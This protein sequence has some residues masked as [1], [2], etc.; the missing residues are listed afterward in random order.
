[1]TTPSATLTPAQEA[2]RCSRMTKL[3][4]KVLQQ[5]VIADAELAH[6]MAVKISAGLMRELGG[7]MLY[8]PLRDKRAGLKD[9]G[10]I[11]AEI[12][13]HVTH[14][15]LASGVAFGTE[16]VYKVM[17]ATNASRPTV[18][19]VLQRMRSGAVGPEA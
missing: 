13:R 10:R 9:H 4:A 5:G 19:R 6:T 1:M 7:S 14:E 18:W 2:D 8:V 3:V 15:Q 11:E 17:S 16:A 12:L